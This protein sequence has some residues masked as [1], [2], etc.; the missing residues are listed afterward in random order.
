LTA[1][2]AYSAALTDINAVDLLNYCFTFSGT[3]DENYRYSSL[4]QDKLHLLMS[5]QKAW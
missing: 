5:W 3:N 2:A 1:L 4:A